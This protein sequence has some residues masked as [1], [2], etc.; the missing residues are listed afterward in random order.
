MSFFKKMKDRFTKPN[1]TISLQL[2]KSSF[3]LGENVEG[4]VTVASSEEFDAKEIRCEFECIETKKT[5]SMQYDAAIKRTIP[6]EVQESATLWSA[7]PQLTAPIHLTP[8]FTQNY[9]TNI[10]IPAGGRPTYH[11]VDQNVAWSLKGV[12]AI[13]GRPDVTSTTVEIQVSP[14]SAS[15]VIREKEIVREV[16]MIPCKYCGTLMVQT[17][18]VCPNCGAKRTG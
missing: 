2:S 17:E 18:T 1:A 8:G 10:N 13:E 3:A 15:P 11:S 12:I 14:P 4:T 16:V 5:I 7:R 6:K 9:P